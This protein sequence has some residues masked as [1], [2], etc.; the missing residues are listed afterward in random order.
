MVATV[1][2]ANMTQIV[3]ITV[4]TTFA[5][6]VSGGQRRSQVSPVSVGGTSGIGLVVAVTGVGISR[7]GTRA[8]TRALYPLLVGRNPVRLRAGRVIGV[9]EPHVDGFSNGCVPL[10]TQICATLAGPRP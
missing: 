1:R 8:R 2:T 3:A 10:A 5:Q 9:F 6:Y 7:R 4:T